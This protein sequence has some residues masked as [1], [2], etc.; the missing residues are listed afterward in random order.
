MSQQRRVKGKSAKTPV[1]AWLLG[2]GLFGLAVLAFVFSRREMTMIKRGEIG[3]PSARKE[4]ATGFAAY[5]KS[6]ICQ[7]CHEEAFQLWETSHHAMAERPVS[8]A[9][10]SRAF[11]FRSKIKHGSQESAARV[12]NAHFEVSTMGGNGQLQP[13]A[14]ERVLGVD[15]LRQFLI[16]WAGGRFQATEL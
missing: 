2:A 6:A 15:P 13:F 4:D 5:A 16:P 9:L 1:F 12:R 11:E 14:V 10:D 7:S 3:S 8:S